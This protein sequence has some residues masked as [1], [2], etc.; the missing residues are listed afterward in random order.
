MI[1]CFCHFCSAFANTPNLRKSFISHI[2]TE[3][4]TFTLYGNHK[5][6]WRPATHSFYNLLGLQQNEKNWYIRKMHRCLS[7]GEER[8][9]HHF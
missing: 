1:L 6:D 3:A 2:H 9:N 7:Q 8:V 5:N 4:T